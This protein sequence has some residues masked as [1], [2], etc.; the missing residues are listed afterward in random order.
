MN[1][2]LHQRISDLDILD[3]CRGEESL[4]GICLSPAHNRAVR[5]LEHVFQALEVAVGDDMTNGI[6][7]G[8]AVR[9]ELGVSDFQR[10][11]KSVLLIHRDKD[12]VGRR[13]SLASVERSGP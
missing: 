4:S 9:I 7:I 2:R 6:R 8:R 1:S 3:D 5:L 13:T 10:F 12:V 11:D